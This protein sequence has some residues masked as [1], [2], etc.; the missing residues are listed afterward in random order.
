[1]GGVPMVEVI[2]GV[3]SGRLN[4][5]YLNPDVIE[6]RDLLF[7][8]VDKGY[9]RKEIAEILKEMGIEKPRGGDYQP[10]DIS[11]SLLKWR[12]RADRENEHSHFLKSIRTIHPS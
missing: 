11:M 12:K 3:I 1:M 2:I 5:N 9:T 7:S 10:I 8:L 6:R 4:T